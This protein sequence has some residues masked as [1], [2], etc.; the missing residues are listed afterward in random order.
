MRISRVVEGVLTGFGHRAGS[1]SHV[2]VT[3]VRL[4][5]SR[6]LLVAGWVLALSS[7]SSFAQVYSVNDYESAY[8]VTQTS[9]AQMSEI[10]PLALGLEFPVRDE[11]YEAP[12][13]CDVIGSS[14]VFCGSEYLCAAE[15]SVA[16]D[17]GEPDFRECVD[18][19][20]AEGIRK[21]QQCNADYRDDLAWCDREYT[22]GTW[23]HDM[24]YYFA[25]QTRNLCRAAEGTS[26]AACVSGCGIGAPLRGVWK[27]IA[28]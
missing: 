21:Q 27:K 14:N 18:G 16:A 13:E 7:Q 17:A 5:V 26:T 4:R 12:F 2:G 15:G 11:C 3:R 20:L 22:P 10:D 9:G 23:R 24:C 28:N 1:P 19:C 8:G 6:M 25:G